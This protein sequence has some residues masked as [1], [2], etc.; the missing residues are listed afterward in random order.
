MNRP[1]CS[2]LVLVVANL[3]TAISAAPAPDEKE[4]G[5]IVI[6]FSPLAKADST[7]YKMSLVIA[8]ENNKQHSETYHFVNKP[9]P[10][11]IA[12]TVKDSLAK[13][14]DVALDE[15]QKKLVVK[16]YEKSAVKS[17]EV[18]LRGEDKSFAPVAKQLAGEKKP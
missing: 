10:I 9:G 1:A 2:L 17:V 16:G 8:S 12:M 11:Q 13:G 14:W 7:D 6:D 4:T 3:A 15:S 5:P 18:S